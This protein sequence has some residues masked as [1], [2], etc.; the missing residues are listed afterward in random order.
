LPINS[1]GSFTDALLAFVLENAQSLSAPDR[2]R[3][4]FIDEAN[5]SATQFDLSPEMKT[6]LETNGTKSATAFLKW[7]AAGQA[8]FMNLVQSPRLEF[9]SDDHA[10]HSHS[11]EHAHEPTHVDREI[12]SSSDDIRLIDAEKEI[13]DAEYHLEQ[14]KRR[15]ASLGREL[16]TLKMSTV[17]LNA[18]E[19]L[20]IAF[21]FYLVVR[22]YMVCTTFD[23]LD[24]D[25]HLRVSDFDTETNST[26][27]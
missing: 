9:D 19:V 24:L 12:I 22:Y 11:H 18:I 8:K 6:Q 20:L 26:L 16:N 7:F 14:E 27:P 5:V 3:T 23:P 15:S 21:L 25:D 13:S 1:F 10:T 2:D 4:I 17:V